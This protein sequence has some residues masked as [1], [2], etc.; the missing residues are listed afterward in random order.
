MDP[1]R[2]PFAP[3]AGQRP[4]EL[5]GRERELKAFEV[6]LERVARGRP[7]RSLV[8]TGLRGVGKTVLLGELRAMAV[9]HKWGAGKIEARPDAE[10]RRPLSAALH[11]AIRDLAVRHRAP[12]RVEEV[13]GV[14]KAFALRANKPDAK[15]R[16]RWQPGIDVPAAQGRADSGDIE[17]DLVELFTDVAELAADVGTGVALLIDEIQDLQPDDVSALCAAC[18]E[19]SQSG[20]PLVV[21]GAGLPH[22]PAVLSASKSYSERLFRYARI[23]RLSREDADFAVMAPIEREDAGIEPEALDAL[24]DASGG[25]PYFIQAYGKAAW[26]AAPSDPITV[27]DVQVAAPEAESELAVGFFGSRYERATPAEREYLQA[28]ASLTQGRDEPA[29]TADVAVFLGRKPSSLSPARDSL[30]K[31]GLVYSAER[32]QI[33]FTVPHFGHYLLGRD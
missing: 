14:L 22:V 7:E 29:G 28:M 17:I 12:D 19:L 24:F 25:Y 9:R 10:L 1:I 16:D 30:M 32:G 2:N 13:L 18:H 31:K 11:R 27:K 21:V 8:L 5:A 33:A 6:V 20:A 26:D 23:D 3:G 15:L 4:P